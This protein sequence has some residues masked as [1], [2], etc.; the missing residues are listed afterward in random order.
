MYLASPQRSG[1]RH[2]APGPRTRANE[3]VHGVRAAGQAACP[4]S[5]GGGTRRVHLVRG[6]GGAMQSMQS[7]RCKAC[8]EAAQ[9]RWESGSLA[10]PRRRVDL[11]DPAQIGDHVPHH[12]RML[13]HNLRHEQRTNSAQQ[14]NILHTS[15]RPGRAFPLAHSRMGESSSAAQGPPAAIP[16]QLGAAGCTFTSST[17][18][19]R[20]SCRTSHI[21]PGAFRISAGALHISAGAS[22]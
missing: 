22:L 13:L 12:A 3:D 7:V 19:W 21:S 10:P 16:T 6:R 11:L 5:T 4:I 9:Q 15:T 1:Q 17:V 8:R 18:A 14:T 20:R 2:T